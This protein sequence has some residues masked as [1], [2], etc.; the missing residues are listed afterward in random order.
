MRYPQIITSE[1]GPLDSYQECPP[2]WLATPEQGFPF[3]DQLGEATRTVLGRSAGRREILAVEYGAKEAVDASSDNLASALAATVGNA[4][5][6]AIYPPAFFGA[7]RRRK[8]VVVLQGAIH[9]GEI[10]GTVAAL[11]L[12]RIIEAGTDLRGKAWPRLRELARDTRLLIIPWLNI[13]GACRWLLPHSIGAPAGLLDRCTFGV[14]GDGKPYQYLAM[15]NRF[16]IPPDQTQFMGA[17][18]NDAGVNLQYD[19]S[20]PERQPETVAWMKYYLAERPDGVLVMHGNAGTLIGPPDAHLPE[21]YQHEVSRL[22][23]AVRQRLL[24]DGLPAARMSWAGLPGL[25]KPGLNQCSAIYHVCGALPVLCEF[26]TGAAP[27]VMTAETMLDIGLIVLEEFLLYAHRDGL[28][29]YE[30]RE[31]AMRTWEAK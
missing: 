2:F 24:R 26:P 20:Q 14:A 3:L 11:N 16:P 27:A 22:G 31:K 6:T 10:T 5:P 12:C 21:G 1:F 19:F 18:F 7:K 9:G 15:K 25:G 29:P 8:P 23:G 30:W 4:D 13:D 17:Y 28:R